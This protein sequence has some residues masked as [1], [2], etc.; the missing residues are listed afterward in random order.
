MRAV[1]EGP[2]TICPTCKGRVE[3]A[4]AD[5][6]YAVELQRADTFGGTEYLEGM[7]AYFHT[8]CYPEGSTRYRR[9]PKPSTGP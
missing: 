5:V 4:D 1:S 7:G 2:Y 9:K 8:R 3:P 6:L